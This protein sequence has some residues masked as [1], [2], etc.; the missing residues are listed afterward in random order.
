MCKLR[1]FYGVE[2]FMAWKMT[3]HVVRAHACV[4]KDKALEYV[5]GDVH[6]Y[7][8]VEIMSYQILINCRVFYE[9]NV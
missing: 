2:V 3:C 7:I 9:R 4:V 5:A 1:K 6:F 8:P